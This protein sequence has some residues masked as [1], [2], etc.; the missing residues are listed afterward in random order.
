MIQDLI[1]FFERN[2]RRN[3]EQLVDLRCINGEINVA[4]RTCEPRESMRD[5][6]YGLTVG[7]RKLDLC[8]IDAM[9]LN[10]RFLLVNPNELRRKHLRQFTGRTYELRHS[11][12]HRQD[13]AATCTP[14]FVSAS[15]RRWR[16]GR[17]Q[18]WWGQWRRH[19]WLPHYAFR[20]YFFFFYYHLFVDYE[21]L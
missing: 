1:D 10:W 21:Q 12:A 3:G 2:L 11:M 18:E 17:R 14:D 19:R 6:E 5:V 9:S 13:R 20:V 7:T 4:L 8:R 15:L 16:R